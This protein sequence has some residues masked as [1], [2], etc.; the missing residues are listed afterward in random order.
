MYSLSRLLSAVLIIVHVAQYACG[1]PADCPS[2]QTRARATCLC[3][4]VSTPAPSQGNTQY[5]ADVGLGC[6]GA[7]SCT[8]TR[9][10]YL[11]CPNGK[12]FSEK[13]GKCRSAATVTC[14]VPST[15]KAATCS[16]RGP[17]TT[18]GRYAPQLALRYCYRY[19][20]TDP[21]MC[22]LVK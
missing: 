21:L 6:T 15:A 19:H 12:L 16:S 11:K 18:D 4:A 14:N 10:K 1:Q 20:H 9:P 5:I 22:L 13:V 2:K 8:G 7:F 17:T 3:Q